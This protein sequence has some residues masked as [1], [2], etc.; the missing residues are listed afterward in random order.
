MSEAGS[1]RVRFRGRLGGFALD[2]AFETPARGVTALFGRSGSG[3]TSVLRCIAG[4]H[5]LTDGFCAVDGEIWQDGAA[6]RPPHRRPVGYVF[7]EASL[8]AHLSVRGNLLYGAPRRGR[9]V[10]G[11]LASIGFDQVVE[12]LGLA[13]LLDRAPATLSGGERQR[14]AIGR[15]LLSNPRL[16]LMDEP[17]SA[18]DRDAK[19][20]ILP[21]LER[22]HDRLALPILYVSHDMGEVER[23]ADRVVL[24]EAGRVTASGPLDALQADPALPLA[25]ARDAAVMLDATV[26]GF[27]AGYGLLELAVPGGLFMVPAPFRPVGERRRLRV[28]AGDVSLAL[29]RPAASTILNVLPARIVAARAM[30]EHEMLAVLGLGPDG[31]GARLICRVTRRSWDRLAL[32][33]GMAVHA[34]VKSVALAPA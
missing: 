28:A 12:L 30:G 32:A 1:I 19:G 17:L 14:V 2:A 7:Q 26:A 34:Q 8:F 16:L 23:L 10:P 5:R 15:A 20:E 21:F 4:L 6:F 25:G 18:L 29:E 3:K 22:L 33:E 24:M 31:A 9:R 11:R 13:G 27:E